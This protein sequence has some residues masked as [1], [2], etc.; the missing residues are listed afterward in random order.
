MATNLVDRLASLSNLEGIPRKE[1]RWLVEH[2]HYAVYEVGTVIGPK[3]KRVDN[4]WIILS[5]KIAIR[6]DRGVGPKLVTDWQTGEVSGM[7][8]YSRMKGPPGDNYIEEKA[9]LLAINVKI[10]P[11]M[12]NHCPT[13]ARNF[14]TSDLQDEKMISLGKLA[15]GLAHELNNPASATVRNAKLLLEGLASKDDAWQELVRA[16]LSDLQFN[17]LM[18]MRSACLTRSTGIKLSP[19]QRADHQDQLSHWLV[20]QQLD[21]APAALLVDTAATTRDLDSLTGIIPREKLDVVLKW[22]VASCSTQTLALEMEHAAG[23]IYKLVDA[24][25]KFTYMDSLAEK[26]FVDVEP[27]IRDTIS[28]LVSKLK[29]KNANITLEIDANL[30]QVYANGSDL[31]QVWYCL[32]DNAI[33]A[34]SKSGNI[35]I[36]AHPE[37]NRVVVRI[38]D[39]GPGIASD[40]IPRI[41]DPFFT[42]KSPG[43][44]T[45]LG[46]RR[47][48]RRYHS[49]ITVYSNPDQTEFR[50]SLLV[51]KP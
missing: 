37:L 19:I 40:V 6:V 36:E 30:P 20:S 13:L 35:C 14:N 16:R 44:G 3:G 2:G 24:V 33:D 7:L 8:P 18:N 32:L 21:T 11:Q 50:V 49:D 31:N 9:E 38:I 48:L 41:F 29:S 12:I 4:L 43:Q 46:T 27:G 45:G 42:T 5:G 28:V 26:G 25:K 15:A 23:Q 1:L 17:K 47:L 51:D 10:F 34:I 39:D 22:V